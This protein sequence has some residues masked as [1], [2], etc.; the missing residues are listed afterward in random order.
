MG[1]IETGVDKLVEIIAQEHRIEAGA[2]AKKLGVSKDVVQEWAEFL[3]EEGMISIEYSLSKMFFVER[4]LSKKELA[5]KAKEYDTK[6]DLFVR[7][8]DT[9][10]RTFEK[11]TEWFENIK[12]QYEQMKKD[13][14]SELE[15]VHEEMKELRHY[16]DLKKNI[17]QDIIQQKLNYQ[18]LM[19]EMHQKVRAEE[20]KY[21]ELI[22]TIDKERERIEH[23]HDNVQELDKKEDAL[24]RRLDA[25][26]KVIMSIDD[27]V[28][29]DKI[30]LKSE[31][32]TLF[33][34]QELAKKIK[35]D[36]I[37][38]R[39]KEIEPLIKLSEEHEKKILDIQ[40]ELIEKIRKKKTEI[41][42]YSHEA[43]L[44]SQQFY[45]F[46]KKEMETG[47]ILQD[48]EEQK[49]ALKLDLD[50]LRKKAEAFVGLTKSDDV[51]KYV[52]DL[53]EKYENFEKRKSS[54][55]DSIK[56]LKDY[57]GQKQ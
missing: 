23:E 17:D 3:E 36:I 35:E 53:E 16:E 48:L 13:L 32:E 20:K 9:S 18:K 40:E 15:E 50:Q 55:Q 28:K 46:F 12:K 43:S 44:V 37:Y 38:K 5:D 24:Q 34:L 11:E 1:S 54:F 42:G 29:R 26:Q 57:L 6:K 49:A 45:Q 19:D 10:I 47:R 52:A 25:L 21:E 2:A 39:E 33:K 4:K 51:K 31:E 30:G 22:A 8:V 7:K 27:Q 56:R 41:E 14:G